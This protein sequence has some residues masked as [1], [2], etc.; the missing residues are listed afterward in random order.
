MR[1]DGIAGMVTLQAVLIDA[2]WLIGLAG[3]LAAV[4]YM[5]W[6]R[7]LNRW[8]WRHTL[9]TPRSRMSV[10]LSLT[11][12]SSGVALDSLT[13]TRPDPWWAVVAWLLLSFLFFIQT[14]FAAR[15]G[16]QHGWDSVTEGKYRQ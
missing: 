16:D 7:Q 9:Q 3:L 5:G 8:Q 13:S 15:A 14:V 12:I 4:G 10:A 1:D 11:L 2:L 6:Y